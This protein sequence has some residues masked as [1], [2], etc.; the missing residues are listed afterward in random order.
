MH[1]KQEKYLISIQYNVLISQGWCAALGVPVH[2]PFFLQEYL[3]SV[4]EDPA[5]SWRHIPSLVKL[6]LTLQVKDKDRRYHDDIMG[7]DGKW[8]VS[9]NGKPFAFNTLWRMLEDQ[10][11]MVC[12]GVYVKCI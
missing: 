7:E 8:W 6:F 10:H 1:V 11:K 9:E 2:T 5:R 3:L 12:T 4:N